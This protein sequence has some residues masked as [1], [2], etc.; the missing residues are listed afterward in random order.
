MDELLNF[1]GLD[2]LRSA[3]HAPIPPIQST[4]TAALKRE[5]RFVK[6]KWLCLVCK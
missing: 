6:G 4:K 1:A 2:T 5:L 3:N